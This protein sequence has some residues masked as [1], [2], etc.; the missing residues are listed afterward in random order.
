MHPTKTLNFDGTSASFFQKYWLIVGKDVVSICLK[1]LNRLIVLCE[2]NHAY[3]ALILKKSNPLNMKHFR[4]I[5]LYIVIY[6][7]I[8]E[9]IV[10]RLKQILLS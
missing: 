9:V 4:P 6:K 3:I 8:V 7:I 10:Y 5:S 2:L 1:A